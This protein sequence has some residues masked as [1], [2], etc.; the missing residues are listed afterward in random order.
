MSKGIDT[1]ILKCLTCSELNTKME[2]IHIIKVVEAPCAIEVDNRHGIVRKVIIA[3][4]DGIERDTYA[5]INSNGEIALVDFE[6]MVS[7]HP[8]FHNSSTESLS[9]LNDIDV[10]VDVMKIVASETFATFTVCD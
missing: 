2:K 3:D 9:L 7:F 8:L 4:K 5:N 6:N 10:D 1:L